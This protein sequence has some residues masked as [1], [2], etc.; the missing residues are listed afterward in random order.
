MLQIPSPSAEPEAVP[1]G[2]L[3]PADLVL[4]SGAVAAVLGNKAF[5][6]Y[7]P[8]GRDASAFAYIGRGILDGRLPYVDMWDHKAPGI[9]YANALALALLP[10]ISQALSARLIELCFA[11][12]A[13]GVF[14]LIAGAWMEGPW[15]ALAALLFG[16]FGTLPRLN[17]GGNF[18]EVYTLLPLVGAY[19]CLAKA[20]MVAQLRWAFWAGTAAGVALV[21]SPKAALDLAGFAVFLS[22]LSLRR[23]VPLRWALRAGCMLLLGVVLIIVPVLT[24][25][26]SR[27]ALPELFD[28]VVLY[29]LRYASGIGRESTMADLGERLKDLGTAGLL[30]W[31]FAPL[32][33]LALLTSRQR[34][35]LGV[36]VLAWLA[37]AL[38]ATAFGGRFY[39]HY[40]IPVIP[41]LALLSACGMREALRQLR[42]SRLLRARRGSWSAAAVSVAGLFALSV[43][44]APLTALE[45]RPLPLSSPEA[46][47]QAAVAGYVAARTLPGDPILVW[48]AESRVY[49]LAGREAPTRFFYNYP[50]VPF[51]DGVQTASPRQREYRK[52]FLADVGARAPALVVLPPAHQDFTGLPEIERWLHASYV[53]AVRFDSWVVLGRR[54]E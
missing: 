13:V 42:I 26:G 22:V 17:E 30:L 50:L 46:N 20:T 24:Y 34:F 7:Q 6:L 36:L 23:L 43:M 54:P 48:G 14:F 28:Q 31:A 9:Y 3:G 47:R 21:F 44:A 15:P 4:W 19:G 53:E 51:A 10:D 40:F 11:L 1:G 25:F 37:A 38:L 27:D 18:T 49:L 41:P 32:G 16:F 35:P 39:R 12:A 52:E 45:G 8:L 5:E 2:H 29:N 33:A